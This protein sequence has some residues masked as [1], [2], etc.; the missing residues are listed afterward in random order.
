MKKN[1]KKIL[2][3]IIVSSIILTVFVPSVISHKEENNIDQLICVRVIDTIQGEDDKYYINSKEFQEFFNV[4]NDKVTLSSFSQKMADKLNLLEN[5]DMISDETVSTLLSKYKLDETLIKSFNRFPIPS[6]STVLNIFSG[7]FF[8]IKGEKVSSFF[9]LSVVDLPFF[10]GN[11]T[12]GLVAFGKFIGSG[13]IF[14]L[15]FLGLRYIYD[16][17]DT[18]YDF[19]YFPVITGYIVGFSGILIHIYVDGA[20]VPEYMHG[21]YIFGAGMSVFTYWTM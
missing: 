10:N 21:D 9:E 16:Y 3:L 15:G 20:N 13:S 11:I 18:E 17:D 4:I 5:Y 7:T 8:G 2:I 6:V 12:A 14:S 19:P 1:F